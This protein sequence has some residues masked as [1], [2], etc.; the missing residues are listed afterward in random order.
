MRDQGDAPL[1][2]SF[3]MLRLRLSRRYSLRTWFNRAGSLKR[4]LASEAGLRS[5]LAEVPIRIITSFGDTTLRFFYDTGADLMVIPLYVARHEGIPYREEFPGMLGSL[6]WRSRPLLLRFR[7]GAFVPFRQDTPLG[8]R[9]RRRG[10][11]PPRRRPIR[12]PERLCSDCGR[13]ISPGQ[14]SGVPDRFR[15]AQ[16]RQAA[17]SHGANLKIVRRVG[18]GGTFSAPPS[19]GRSG[20]PS[21]REPAPVQISSQTI[22]N[23][24]PM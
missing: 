12:F 4:L 19:A 13:S 23:H 21:K 24:E 1:E 8:L 5:N 10:A 7:P 3:L 20:Q 18:D 9:L 16:S 6:P 2:R 14:P 17:R 15:E 11:G 22:A